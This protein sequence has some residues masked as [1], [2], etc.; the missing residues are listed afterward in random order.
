MMGIVNATRLAY[1]L[2]GDNIPLS[3]GRGVRPTLIQATRANANRRIC[4]SGFGRGRGDAANR[5]RIYIART[6]EF[7]RIF[8]FTGNL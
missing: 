4:S 7:P 6:L 2:G 5:M 1:H 3:S 8:H